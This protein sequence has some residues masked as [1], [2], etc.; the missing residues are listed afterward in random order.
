MDAHL[1]GGGSSAADAI[2]QVER[3][4]AAIKAVGG[5]GSIDWHVRTSIPANR[6][7][8]PWGEAYVAI[9]EQLAADPQLWVTSLD[10]IAAWVAS[11]A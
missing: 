4:V 3:Y 11:R 2:E 5:F 6:E 10:E 9:L 8:R 7:F 1:F